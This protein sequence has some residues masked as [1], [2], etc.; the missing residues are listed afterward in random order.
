VILNDVRA[1]LE[2]VRSAGRLSMKIHRCSLLSP[3][4][5]SF[6]NAGLPSVFRRSLF[7]IDA[8]VL[9]PPWKFNARAITP[10]RGDPSRNTGSRAGRRAE[11]PPVD[12]GRPIR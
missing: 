8:A 9:H 4:A 10:I 11:S 1:A 6:L 3:T 7:P 5:L 2:K 12:I